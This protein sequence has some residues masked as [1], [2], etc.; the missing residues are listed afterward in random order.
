MKALHL[1]RSVF[2]YNSFRGAQAEIVGHVEGGGD[3]LVLMPTGG[4]KSLCY[5]LPSL[6]RPGVGIVVSPLIALMQDQVD[7]LL[8]AGVKAAFLNSSQDAAT[9]ADTER[10]LLRGELDLLYVAPERVMMDRFLGQLDHL[11]EQGRIAL[12]AIDEAHCVSQWGHDFRPEYIQLSVLHERYPSIPRIALTATAD[13]L[14]REEI[15]HRLGLG[16]ARI[17]VSSFDRPNIRYSIVERDNPRKQLLAFLA[18]HRNEA[19]IVYCLSRKKVD[20]T[21]LW[22]QTQGVTALAYHAGLDA[23][24]RREHQQR[25]V[26]DEAVVMVAT[27]AFG[28]GIDKPDVRY[29]VHLD[30]PKSLEAYYQETGRAG[31]DGEPAEAWMTYGLNDVVIHRQ[32]IDESAAPDEQKRIERQKLDA[33]LAYCEAA[34]CRR[35]VLLNYFGEDTGACGN[36]DTCQTPPELWDGT[37]AAQKFMSAALRTGQRFGAAHL[38]D[39]LRGK[40]T[41]KVAQFNHDQLPT[42]G[43]GADLDEATWRSV[44]RQ[45]LASSLLYADAQHYGALKL[46]GNAKPVLKGE[47]TLMLR[48]QAPAKKKSSARPK[49]V[50]PADLPAGDAGLFDALRLWRGQTARE[51]GVPAYVILHDRTLHELAARKPRSMDELLNVGGIGEAKAARYGTALLELLSAHE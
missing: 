30:L 20:E 42:F 10:R 27:I 24:T 44:A 2:G 14:T 26:R 39:I 15:V 21:A 28:M 40:A 37:T 11:H 3:A 4:G 25:F 31:R 7:A 48:R 16:D 23:A 35:T 13:A 38:I 33:M 46:T 5:Q 17:F 41:E 34:G 51:Q 1:L 50:F 36:C 18:E 12:F 49:A 22:L 29:V 32:R 47:T 45:L 8:Q 6:L 9:A 19:G 43:V